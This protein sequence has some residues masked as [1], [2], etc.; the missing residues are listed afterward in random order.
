MI[1]IRFITLAIIKDV[2]IK[3]FT[4]IDT[5]AV[6]VCTAAADTF[7]RVI[8]IEA[9]DVDFPNRVTS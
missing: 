1:R 4:Y 6:K 9:K 2:L 7:F 8:F 5:V 3:M